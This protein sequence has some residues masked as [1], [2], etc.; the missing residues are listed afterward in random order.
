[1]RTV[2]VRLYG[3]ALWGLPKTLQMLLD[4]KK[5]IH[6]SPNS[7]GRIIS[8][9]VSDKG[10]FYIIRPMRRPNLKSIIGTRG[11]IAITDGLD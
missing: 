1:M 7:V 11:D 3:K 5:V 2:R 9:E 6:C 4:G 10:A 8:I